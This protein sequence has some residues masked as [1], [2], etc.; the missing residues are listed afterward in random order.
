MTQ[1]KNAISRELDPMPAV[2]HHD[3]TALIEGC[4][5]PLTTGFIVCRK[6]QGEIASDSLVFVAPPVQ[7]KGDD[8]C[9]TFKVFFL[10]GTPAYGGSI[11]KGTTRREVPWQTILKRNTF[12][13]SDRGI[14]GIS[15]TVRYLLDDGI[16]RT[17]YSQ[18]EIYLR[19]MKKGYFPLHAVDSDPHF[20]WSW[21]E[22]NRRVK[23][24]SG[25]RTFVGAPQ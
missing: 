23:A 13:L 6:T 3:V 25:M 12:E 17:T 18:G 16:E 10:D 19:V 20:I 8:P 5:L 9:V 24:T 21:D 14:W 7:C 22:K 15:Y 2:P 11:A 4:G 1:H